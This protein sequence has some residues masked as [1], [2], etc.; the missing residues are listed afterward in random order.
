MF[1]KVIFS[2]A[3]ILANNA[4]MPECIE[5]EIDKPDTYIAR[6]TNIKQITMEDI[7]GTYKEVN[8]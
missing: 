7:Y 1:G 2:I 4:V 6:Q 5:Y 8:R 3:F